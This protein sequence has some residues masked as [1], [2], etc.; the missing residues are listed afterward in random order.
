MSEFPFVTANFAITADGKISTRAHTPSDFS[1]PRDKR[2]L[3][4]I[5]ATADAILVGRATLEQENMAMGL[6]APELRAQRTAAGRAPYPTRVLLTNSGRLA[7][8]LR[9]F[10]EPVAPILIYATTQMPA[11]NRAALAPLATLHLTPGDRVDLHSMMRSLRREHGIARLVCE[12]GPGVLRSL[13]EAGLVNELHVTIC[14]LVFGG[15]PALTLTGRPGS[16]LPASISLELDAM[17][18]HDGECFLRY[19]VLAPLPPA[20]STAMVAR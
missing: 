4:E 15:E 8:T 19:T 11:S 6:P 10:Q 13:L 18:E 20:D 3:L 17:E 9:V 14:P 2:R 7:P 1:S 16:F 5:R 12:G